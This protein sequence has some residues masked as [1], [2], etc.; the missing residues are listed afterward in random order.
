MVSR[1]LPLKFF[2]AKLFPFRENN[3]FAIC[4]AHTLQH[5]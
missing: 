5:K 3:A 2:L 1:S 4:V